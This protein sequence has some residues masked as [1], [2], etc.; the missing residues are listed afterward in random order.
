MEM[1]QVRYFLAVCDTLNF[2]RAAEQCSVA[3]PS[4]TRAI[5]KL[6][7][8]LGGLLLRRERNRTH[9]TELGK[10]VKPHLQQI[11]AANRSAREQAQGYQEKATARLT[12]GVMCTIGPSRLIGFFERMARDIPALEVS[13]REATGG[14]L[15][16]EL[17]Q[18]EL[19]I[20]LI[21]LPDFP[22]RLDAR[23]LYSERYVVA[24]PRGH[25]FE[26]MDEVPV[27]ELDQEDYLSR[28]NCEYPDHFDALGVPGRGQVNIRYRSERED[29]IQAMILA[30]MGC[31]VMAESMPMLPGIVTRNLSDPVISRT[32]R[33]VTVS[34]RRYSPTVQALIR[35]AQHHD[36]AA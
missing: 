15:I 19:E 27:A 4:L 30:G 2:T 24:F 34:G 3:Q 16:E 20:A 28:V 13:T 23:P 12:L 7:D 25:R 10:I 1:H 21:G 29:W 31:T 14:E 35:L 6:E 26:A 36:W 17:M 8:E 11:Y 9:V 33:L 5:Q 32:V 18:G 22:D